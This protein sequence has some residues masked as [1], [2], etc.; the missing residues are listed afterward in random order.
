[1]RLSFILLFI[2][3]PKLGWHQHIKHPNLLLPDPVPEAA[4]FSPPI[5]QHKGELVCVKPFPAMP[6]GFWNDEDGARYRTVYF[7]HFPNVWHHG[8]FCETIAHDGLIIHGRWDAVLNPGGVWIGT[9]EIYRQVEK[10]PEMIESIVIG[11]D[12]NHDVRVVIVC[13]PARGA[14]PQ[15]RPHRPDQAPDS[16]QRHAAPCAGQGGAGRG[17]PAHPQWQDRRVGGAQCC[18]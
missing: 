11:Q 17:H 10:L 15:R 2:Y 5:R 4:P 7:D 3:Y 14:G 1:V 12:W 16:R 13:A 18:P 8:D 6:V 9:A